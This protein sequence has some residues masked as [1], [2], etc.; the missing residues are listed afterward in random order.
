MRLIDVCTGKKS[1]MTS[2]KTLIG[3]PWRPAVLRGRGEQRKLLT[4]EAR[5]GEDN[6]DTYP[7]DKVRVVTDNTVEAVASNTAPWIVFCRR[8]LL[9]IHIHTMFVLLLLSAEMI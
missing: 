6:S 3:L 8:H 7:S 5:G 9:R 1:S 2:S 4:E